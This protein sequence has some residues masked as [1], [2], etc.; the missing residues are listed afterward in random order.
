MNI[1]GLLVIGDLLLVISVIGWTGLDFGW[2]DLL[3]G[4]GWVDLVGWTFS[5]QSRR[6]AEDAE[7]NAEDGP[8]CFEFLREGWMGLNFLNR[9]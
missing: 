3:G 6:G 1:L 5:T 7:L 8:V 9:R 4:L 2:V